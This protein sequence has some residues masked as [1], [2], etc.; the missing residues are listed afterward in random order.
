ML[1][2]LQIV[3]VL[4]AAAGIGAAL[5]G[6]LQPSLFV[7]LFLKAV[8]VVDLFLF[9]HVVDASRFLIR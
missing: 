5:A 3:M 9:Q 4:V 7:T 1:L 8:S 6:N 2:A